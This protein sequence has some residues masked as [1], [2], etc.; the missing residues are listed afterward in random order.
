VGVWIGNATGEGRAELRSAI[1]SAP[2]LFEL[3]SA[4]EFSGPL[5]GA[6]FPQ[7]AADLKAAEVCALSGFPPGRDCQT[8]KTV[9]LPA[10]APPHRPCPYCTQV[11]IGGREEK[12]FLLPPA[13]EWYYRRWN[14]DYKGL[15]S[16]T[17]S[18]G[19]DFPMALF[20]PEEGTGVF[21]PRELDGSEGRVVFSAAHREDSALIHWHLDNEYLGATS[22]FHEMEARPAPGPHTLTLVDRAGRTL[23]R[24]FRVLG[25]TE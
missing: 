1:T 4:L 18:P 24:R 6:W 10:T 20:N 12:R 2:V 14:L 11:I 8:L 13:E 23:T 3:F 9:F 25:E 19:A 21:V 5:S 22:V 15:P 7:P 17:G 16:Q